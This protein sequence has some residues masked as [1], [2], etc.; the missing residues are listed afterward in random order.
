MAAVVTSCGNKKAEEPKG[1]VGEKMGEMTIVKKDNGRFTI[2]DKDNY[3]LNTDYIK[4]VDQGKFV[5]A[6]D[7]SVI[8]LMSYHSG[9]FCHCDSFAVKPL[10]PVKAGE[11]S[12]KQF[13]LASVMGGSVA[14]DIDTRTSVCQIDGKK[15]EVYPLA[16][17][18]V[19]YKMQNGYGIAEQGKSE[20]F[21][22]AECTD[23]VVVNASGTVYYL[24]KTPDWAGYLDT[25]GKDVKPLTPAQFNA[26]K[27]A[28]TELWSEANG[29]V[30]ART[31]TK[32]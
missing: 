24:I 19:I 10:Y 5:A 28:G 9:D 31:V 13:I 7:S 2:Y 14:F 17:G 23:I 12:S 3:D 18:A 20:A 27:K 21:M 29:K 6:Y 11:K 32:I 16:N 15:Q 4:V 30:S 22:G 26:A 1:P 8:V 25:T